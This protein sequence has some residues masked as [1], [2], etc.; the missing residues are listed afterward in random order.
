MILLAANSAITRGYNLHSRRIPRTSTPTNEAGIP[1]L[2][3]N[4]CLNPHNHLDSTSAV[5][6]VPVK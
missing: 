1:F 6:F 5:E 3:W 4:M 2:V